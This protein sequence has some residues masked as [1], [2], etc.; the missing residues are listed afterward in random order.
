MSREQIIA[1]LRAHEQAL[2]DAGVVRLSLFGSA[3]R[4]EA[5]PDSDIDIAVRLGEGFS[6]G[7]FDYF[8]RLEQTGTT[9]FADTRR[10]GRRSGRACSQ[11]TFQ[12]EIDRDRALA[13]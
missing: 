4:D 6:T 12:N 8:W 10:Q 3:A 5:G 11:R 2:K 9:P 7:G 1:T 13:F